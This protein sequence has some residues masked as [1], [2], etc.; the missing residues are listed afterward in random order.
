MDLL[1]FDGTPTSDLVLGTFIIACLIAYVF[2]S[3]Q[4][5]DR[6]R[7]LAAKRRTSSVEALVHMHND[8]ALDACAELFAGFDE[9]RS[10][11]SRVSRT[12]SMPVLTELDGEDVPYTPR[13]S[14]V[15]S[16][17]GGRDEQDEQ[18][19]DM[20]DTIDTVETKDMDL[21]EILQPRDE[22]A[23]MVW[24][25]AVVACTRRHEH[26]RVLCIARCMPR[27][28]YNERQ[29]ATQSAIFHEFPLRLPLQFRTLASLSM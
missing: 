15:F 18:V 24:L 19:E 14:E 22:G 2:F 27:T 5:G 9:R 12:P 28:A 20:E 7:L 25:H 23:R 3:K 21:H 6:E 11:R 10:P 29:R 8:R 4:R 16:A 13:T 26:R 1:V 17:C